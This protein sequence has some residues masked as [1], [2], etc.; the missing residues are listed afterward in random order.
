MSDAS[1]CERIGL[2]LVWSVT[3]LQ[4]GEHRRYAVTSLL[5]QWKDKRDERALRRDSVLDPDGN[6]D[7]LQDYLFDWL[8]SSDVARDPQNLSAIAL[9][10]HELIRHNLFSYTKYT[11][12]LIARGD[13]GLSTTNVRVF[14]QWFVI[15]DDL[16]GV[17]GIGIVSSQFFEVASVARRRVVCAARKKSDTIWYSSS[18]NTRGTERTRN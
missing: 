9:L 2:L 8:D 4:Y 6:D 7:F 11:Q 14:L 5:R 1:L 16:F 12:R 18:G 17:P 3:P 15:T 13:V 10:Y